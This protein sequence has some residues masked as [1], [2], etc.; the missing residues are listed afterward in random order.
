MSLRKELGKISHVSFGLGG[1]QDAMIGISFGLG[2]NSG[3]GV[4]DFWGVWSI[5]RSEHAKWT[6]QDRI[7]DAGK[8]VMRINDLLS[9][10]K[11]SDVSQLEGI[12]VEVTFEG[13]TLKGWRILTEVL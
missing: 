5:D 10:A 8:M 12:P 3:W 7:T 4:S 13:N 11:I 9:Q 2:G 6:E 1:Y